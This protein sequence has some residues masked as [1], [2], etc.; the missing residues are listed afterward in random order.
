MIFTDCPP[1]ACQ[2]GRGARVAS[3]FCRSA[4][5][6]PAL[7]TGGLPGEVALDP[8][9]GLD[10]CVIVVR[11]RG[12]LVFEAPARRASKGWPE[13][14]LAAFRIGPASSWTEIDAVAGNSAASTK[15]FTLSS[16]TC[17]SSA[18]SLKTSL[19][20]ADSGA[21]QDKVRKGVKP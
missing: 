21:A 19:T 17:H 11:D 8:R 5:A 14:V 10:R 2:I 16:T 4:A 7:A 6:A 20:L 12:A 18:S 3:G 9:R 1:A 13:P 15:S